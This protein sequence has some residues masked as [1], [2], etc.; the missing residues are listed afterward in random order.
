MKLALAQINPMVGDIEKN[1]EKIIN[2]I[3]NAIS[4]NIDLICFPELSI[5]GYPP[6]DL[7]L[8]TQFISDNLLS[9][10]KIIS[11]TKDIGVVIGFV[12]RKYENLFNSA[13]LIYNKKIIGIYN[14]N[15]LPN[16][17][18][19]DEKRY[20]KAG[21]KC[22]VF[23]FKGMKIGINI[24]E[25]IWHKN[26]PAKMQIKKG[27]ELIININAS[28]F[29]LERIKQREKNLKDRIKECKS[30]IAYVNLVGGQDDL[31]FD[32]GSMFIDRNGKVMA[33]GRQFE[34]DM[35]IV[36]LNN[37]SKS[38]N[39]L[40]LG[41]EEE[42]YRA[43]LL[44]VKDYVKK[45][46]FKKVVIG[47][48][49]GIDSALTL[50]IAVDALGSENVF[51][52]FMPS[53]YTADRSKVDAEELAKNLNVKLHSIS[54]EN[55]QESF[56]KSLSDEFQDKKEGITEENLQARIRG[57]ILM[58]FSN[59]Y[60]W[61]VL[62]TG[63]K[64]EVS[65]GYCTLYGDMAG[66]FALLKDVPKTLVYKL[67]NYRN[68]IS[69][70]IP[71]DIIIREPTAELKENQKDQ[72]TLPPYEILDEIIQLYVEENKSVEDIVKKGFEK[73]IVKKVIYLIDKNEYK[74]RQSAPGPKITHRSFGK[75]WRVPITKP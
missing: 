74:R 64:S 46:K 12:D 5:T 31:I 71:E 24:C 47:L 8:K 13:A 23:N 41:Y 62:S 40:S 3:K 21:T 33:K 73:E 75:D 17:G 69:K 36:D 15:I 52:I 50:A 27:A 65:V 66:G 29:K 45:N 68:T 53:K 20:F 72:D 56:I 22:P 6:E 11:N 61:L 18:V 19:F 28:P 63:N 10:K 54:I 39:I 67:A 70:V 32:G 35:L 34:E 49:G 2:F 7:L 48:S 14:K 9:L 4:Q 60:G 59:K 42:A 16:Y 26:G 37:L 57:N 1:T 25:D 44:A 58:A 30:S 55:I 51:A 38:K 43:L